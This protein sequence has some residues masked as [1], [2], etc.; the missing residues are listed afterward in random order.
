MRTNARTSADATA[1]V[2]LLTANALVDAEL[3]I[4]DIPTSA[5]RFRYIRTLLLFPTILQRP[6]VFWSGIE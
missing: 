3:I 1:V 2:R 4:S 6:R 5:T